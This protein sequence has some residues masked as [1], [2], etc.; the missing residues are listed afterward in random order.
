MAELS[1]EDRY[2]VRKL[3][4]DVDK[5]ALDVQKAQQD[6]DRFMLEM[7]RKYNLMDQEAAID[8]RTA[9]IKGTVPAR[10]GKARPEASLTAE[11]KEAAD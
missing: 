6:L 3:Q 4:M 10:N 9:A 8:P 5:K 11:L 7:E 2:Q 1:A